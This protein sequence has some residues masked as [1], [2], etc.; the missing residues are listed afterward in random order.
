MF[1]LSKHPLKVIGLLLA[2]ARTLLT[3]YGVEGR[4]TS[5]EERD[6]ITY[7]RVEERETMREL[8]R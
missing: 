7:L 5:V 4:S 2:Q 1:L 8:L 6:L 3:V